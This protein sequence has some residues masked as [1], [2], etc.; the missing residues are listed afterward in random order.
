M[1]G[2]TLIV[3]F[4]ML[5][6]LFPSSVSSAQ[7]LD[8]LTLTASPTH[9]EI[10]E[11]YTLSLSTYDLGAPRSSIE[12]LVNGTELTEQ[13]DETSI[14]LTATNIATNIKA[15]VTLADGTV[16][17]KS[18]SVSPYRVDLVISAETTAPAFYKG[19]TLPTS[20]SDL[21]IKALVFYNGVP[22]SN[23]H[24]YLWKVDGRTQNGGARYGDNELSF[25]T[26]FQD[27]IQVSVDIMNSHNTVIAG[28]TAVIPIA[29]PELYFY[30]NNPLRGLSPI[31]MS[32]PYIFIGE[33]MNVRAE[34]YFMDKDLFNGEAFAQWELNGKRTEGSEADPQEITLRKEGSAGSSKLSFHIR[35]MKQLLQGVEKA[36]T[37][38]F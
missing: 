9:P 5:C 6:I 16:L 21:Q 8:S 14:S 29:E 33:E 13:E 3:G 37:I 18:Y 10:G 36:I 25:E 34:A 28:E 22:I 17:E 27:S 20:G 4:W 1:R 7:T 2:I 23:A 32:D 19:R 38:R 26:G 35:N 30:E 31:I 15:R 24:S 11:S 12:W